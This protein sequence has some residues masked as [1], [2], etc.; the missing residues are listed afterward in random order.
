MVALQEPQH[1]PPR[2]VVDYPDDPNMFVGQVGR[3]DVW[4]TTT[5]GVRYTPEVVA[6]HIVLVIQGPPRA[7]DGTR[8]AGVTDWITFEDQQQLWDRHSFPLFGMLPDDVRACVEVGLAGLERFIPFWEAHS[9][10]KND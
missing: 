6:G 9:A 8:H 5:A 10:A 1:E 4:L 2:V 7:D 3:W